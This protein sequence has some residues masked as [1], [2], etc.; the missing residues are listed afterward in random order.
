MI[1]LINNKNNDND[2]SNNN[3]EYNMLEG[4]KE[5]DNFNRE[6]VVSVIKKLLIYEITVKEIIALQ[7]FNII[8]DK[9]IEKL[10]NEHEKDEITF[11]IFLVFI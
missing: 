2:E 5:S 11:N 10:T 3:V 1:N 6:M 4:F 9:N 8:I 7:N